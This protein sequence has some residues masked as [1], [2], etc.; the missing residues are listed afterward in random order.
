MTI[1]SGISG[2]YALVPHRSRSGPGPVALPLAIIADA[3]SDDYLVLIKSCS[4]LTH[5]I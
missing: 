3:L 1:M 5:Q 2:H 4:A